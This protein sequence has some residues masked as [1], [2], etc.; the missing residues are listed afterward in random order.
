MDPFFRE[1]A[2][3]LNLGAALD[4]PSKDAHLYPELGMSTR[5]RSC[6]L[7]WGAIPAKTSWKIYQ[8]PFVSPA[9]YGLSLTKTGVPCSPL[10]A[11]SREVGSSASAAGQAGARVNWCSGR[12]EM[13]FSPRGIPFRAN[14]P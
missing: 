14:V 6:L 10:A 5:S 4:A 12:T 2:L 13:D 7:E 11:L 1:L 9:R 8:L 3:P